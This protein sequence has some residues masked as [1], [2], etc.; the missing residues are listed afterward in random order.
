MKWVFPLHIILIEVIC[1]EISLLLGS[2]P[3]N[4]VWCGITLPCL[5]PLILDVNRRGLHPHCACE[6]HLHCLIVLFLRPVILIPWRR[7]LVEQV[8]IVVV[9]GVHQG[10]RLEEFDAQVSTMQGALLVDPSKLTH[11]HA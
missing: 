1:V 3:P 2:D 6:W 7:Y 10:L 9:D 5:V 4:K 11:I 8:L